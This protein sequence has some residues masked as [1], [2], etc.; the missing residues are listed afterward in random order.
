MRII[1]PITLAILTTIIF[2]HSS[3][4]NTDKVNCEWGLSQDT[5]GKNGYCTFSITGSYC[6]F[7]VVEIR[8]LVMNGDNTKK[9]NEDIK[10]NSKISS[11]QNAAS[12]IIVEEAP[13]VVDN[14]T[15][16]DDQENDAA[17]QQE[18]DQEPVTYYENDNYDDDLDRDYPVARSQVIRRR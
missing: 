5:C 15:T 9:T 3:F 4:A 7:P 2:S 17:Y 8:S 6:V 12:V 11:D 16:E 1:T 10:N 13:G 18:E 14:Q